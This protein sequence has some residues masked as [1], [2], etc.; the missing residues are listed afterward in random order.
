[1]NIKNAAL[2][3][4]VAFA[5]LPASAGAAT[6]TSSADPIKE[7]CSSDTIAARALGTND[8]ILRTGGSAERETLYLPDAAYVVKRS[9][10]RP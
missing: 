3:A 2:G 7:I 9:R 1:M 4:C 5:C 8:R 10:E 6:A